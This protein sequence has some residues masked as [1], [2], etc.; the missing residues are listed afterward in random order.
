MIETDE[1]L[2]SDEY[3]AAVDIPRVD[4]NGRPTDEWYC[5]EHFKTKEEA[6]A[7]ARFHYGADENGMVCIVSTF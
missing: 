4:G 6:L 5:V 3:H 2:Y 7:F 1:E